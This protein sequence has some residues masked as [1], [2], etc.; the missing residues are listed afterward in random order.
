VVAVVATIRATSLQCVGCERV[1]S[2]FKQ[3]GVR[4]SYNRV[5]LS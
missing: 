5:G 2:C 4:T 3:A 1:F